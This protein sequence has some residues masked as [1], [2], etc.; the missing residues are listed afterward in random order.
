MTKS[1]KARMVK[2]KEV[3]Q[4]LSFLAQ[5]HTDNRGK[6]DLAN[7]S[8]AIAFCCEIPLDHLVDALYINTKYAINKEVRVV[9]GKI[10]V[11][12]FGKE[13]V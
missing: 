4:A 13:E 10:V 6:V 2:E 11:G 12:D 8:N 3:L 5:N 9:R 7:L 1:K